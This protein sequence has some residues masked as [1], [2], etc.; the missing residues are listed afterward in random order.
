MAQLRQD[1]YR[2]HDIGRNNPVCCLVAQ[3][4]IHPCISFTS[5][6]CHEYLV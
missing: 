4:G 3:P 2:V 6:D 1:I 5:F